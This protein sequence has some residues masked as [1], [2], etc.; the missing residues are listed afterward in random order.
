MIFWKGVIRNGSVFFWGLVYIFENNLLYKLK[1]HLFPSIISCFAVKLNKTLRVYRG[2]RM[3]LLYSNILPLGTEDDQ[4]TIMDCFNE[5]M[6]IA[7]R[8]EIAV[9]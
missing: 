6:K 1:I 8:V 4:E 9:G 3:K 2:C 5:Q 7:D